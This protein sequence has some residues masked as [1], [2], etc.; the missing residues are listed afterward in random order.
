[1][2]LSTRLGTDASLFSPTLNLT[3]D[4]GKSL[5]A[6]VRQQKRHPEGDENIRD[7]EEDDLFERQYAKEQN[8]SRLT[9]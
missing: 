8:S 6:G 9:R 7:E 5:L 4:T 3:F 2:T 1:M